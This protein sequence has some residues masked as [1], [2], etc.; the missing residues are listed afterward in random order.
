MDRSESVDGLTGG[1]EPSWTYLCLSH[2]FESRHFFLILS[3]RPCLVGILAYPV[4]LKREK[5][6]QETVTSKRQQTGIPAVLAEGSPFR[7]SV[8]LS[9][10][11]LG[12]IFPSNPQTKK[13][14]KLS[15]KREKSNQFDYPRVAFRDY[16]ELKSKVGNILSKAG[17][18]MSPRNVDIR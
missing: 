18:S 15:G 17:K 16:S 5:L 2:P 7:A 8:L 4:R 13:T 11:R 6:I 12:S 1:T 10:P 3:C 9:V 14:T